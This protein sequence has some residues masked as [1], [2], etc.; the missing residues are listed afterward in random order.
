M[1][2][3]SHCVKIVYIRSYSGLHFFRI[4][5]HSDW[6]Q[7]DTK[8]LSVFSPNAGKC[9]KNADQNNSEYGHFLVSEVL[10]FKCNTNIP[11]KCFPQFNQGF[12]SPFGMILF[13]PTLK[14][15]CFSFFYFL[16]WILHSWTFCNNF[17]LFHALRIKWDLKRVSIIF[18]L[19]SLSR[20][21]KKRRKKS[22]CSKNRFYW[23]LKRI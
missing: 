10:I 7:R 17:D 9:G 11:S 13:N 14:S 8:Y 21:I 3:D 23:I 6:I 16:K 4:F 18:L 5:Q 12:D 19:L 20:G 2:S 22:A 1:I 15:K